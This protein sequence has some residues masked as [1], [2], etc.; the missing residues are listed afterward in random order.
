MLLHLQ[1]NVHVNV[2]LNVVVHFV[3]VA[4]VVILPSVCHLQLF[5]VSSLLVFP[6]HRFLSRPFTKIRSYQRPFTI[7]SLRVDMQIEMRFGFAKGTSRSASPPYFLTPTPFLASFV[8][9]IHGPKM[10]TNVSV[11]SLSGC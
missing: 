8:L 11:I 6:H 5:R 7:F 4:V 2:N 9:A 1:N 3:V 10:A